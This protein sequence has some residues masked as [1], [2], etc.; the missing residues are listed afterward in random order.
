MPRADDPASRP[1]A[2]TIGRLIV[3]PEEATIRV[4]PGNRFH[5]GHLRT[6]QGPRVTLEVGGVTIEAPRMRI[7]TNGETIVLE[8]EEK[9]FRTWVIREAPAQ[10]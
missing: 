3:L 6:E 4:A 9:T 10:P 2:E 7:K 1:I 5:I 8:A